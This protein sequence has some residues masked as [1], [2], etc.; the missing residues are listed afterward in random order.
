MIY[1]GSSYEFLDFLPDP[2]HFILAYLEIIKNKK[3]E[4]IKKKNLPNYLSFFIS[5]YSSTV[6]QSSEYAGLKTIPV[7]IQF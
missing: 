4:L 3:F 5:H 6:L 2:T 7:P 1:S